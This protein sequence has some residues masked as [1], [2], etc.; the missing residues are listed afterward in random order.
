MK[1]WSDKLKQLVT[2]INNANYIKF[3]LKSKTIN[4]F[5]NK[6]NNPLP[7][8]LRKY[9]AS[10]NI[11]LAQTSILR[12]QDFISDPSVIPM[13][14][15]STSH[16]DFVENHEESSSNYI[17]VKSPMGGTFYE[18]SSPGQPPFVKIGSQISINQT[19]CIIEAMKLMNEIEAENKGEVVDILV[20][21]GELVECGR[22]LMK[23]KP[24]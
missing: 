16:K 7:L 15:T 13:E 4:L 5:I 9:S 2:A 20:N 3:N 24:I 1:H 17:E 6:E 19:L 14:T 12:N 22:I 8:A 11:F 18:A 21:N 10:Q 23:I